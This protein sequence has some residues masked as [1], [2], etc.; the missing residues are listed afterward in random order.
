MGTDTENCSS[1]L[2][3]IKQIL[4]QVS[5]AKLSIEDIPDLAD[6]VDDYGLDSV[7]IVEFVVSVEKRF[8][9]TLAKDG[10]DMDVFRNLS[11][12]ATFVDQEVGRL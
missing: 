1:T 12:L 11:G 8:G 6:P 7:V 5:G 9:I 4:I 10:M 2:N 3:A